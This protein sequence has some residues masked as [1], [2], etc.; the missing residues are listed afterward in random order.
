MK[1]QIINFVF[2]TVFFWDKIRNYSYSHFFGG[3]GGARGG[4]VKIYIFS[5]P[6]F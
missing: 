3:G 2:I 4:G 1:E 5:L 6:F